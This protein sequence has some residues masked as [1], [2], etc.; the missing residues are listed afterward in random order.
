[1]LNIYYVNFPLW[2]WL[3]P[4]SAIFHFQLYRSGQFYWP[5]KPA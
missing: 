5:R 2:V 4:V 3:T 1:M